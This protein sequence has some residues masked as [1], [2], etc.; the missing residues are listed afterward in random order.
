[1]LLLADVFQEF[2]RLILETY[3]LDPCYYV[4]LPSLT[5]DAFLK[6]TKTEIE[7]LNDRDV[8]LKISK[9]V[10]GGLTNTICPPG[11]RACG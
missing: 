2:K 3:Q 8:H 11:A 7:P 5:N 1:M 10:K 4:S 6:M 9:T